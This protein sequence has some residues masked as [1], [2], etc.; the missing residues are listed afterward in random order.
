[1]LFIQADP[2]NPSCDSITSFFDAS[3]PDCVTSQNPAFTEMKKCFIG[4]V[5]GAA[6]LTCDADTAADKPTADK[7]ADNTGDADDTDADNSD[8]KTRK[9]QQDAAGADLADETEP[10]DTEPAD[11]E[12]AAEEEEPTVSPAQKALFDACPQEISDCGDA[13]ACRDCVS[14]AFNV[15][16]G[17]IQILPS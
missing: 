17:W 8:D 12:P 13:P 2:G 3:F 6:D 11:T 4:F 16:V 7:S 9:L 1:M 15:S 10:A 5:S 14:A